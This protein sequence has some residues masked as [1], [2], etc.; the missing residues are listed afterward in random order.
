MWVGA[1]SEGRSSWIGAIF[2]FTFM[3]YG[4][5][6]LGPPLGQVEIPRLGIESELQLPASAAGLSLCGCLCPDLLFV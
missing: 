5:C 3:F 6:F 2:L 1:L 4:F